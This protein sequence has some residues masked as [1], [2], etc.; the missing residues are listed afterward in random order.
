MDSDWILKLVNE[1]E[2]KQIIDILLLNFFGVL[3]MKMWY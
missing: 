2:D 1:Q 3:L